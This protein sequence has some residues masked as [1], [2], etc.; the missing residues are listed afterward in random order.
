L[1]SAASSL[2]ILGSFPGVQS[3]EQR[4]YYAHPRNGFWPIMAQLLC[5]DP[6]AAYDDR[7]EALVGQGVALW[8]VLC[9]C[10]RKGSLDSAIDA[11]SVVIND[12]NA[13]F[14]AHRNIQALIFNG[15]RAEET[16]IKSV[17]PQLDSPNRPK[18]MHRLPST[19]PAMAMLS[20]EEKAKQWQ[21]IMK[22]IKRA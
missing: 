1:S 9:R 7:V 20:L 5:F 4:Q 11:D 21:L 14:D 12:F 3:L 2:L 22:Y 10:R 18:K 13:F 16:F 6:G 19:S 8:D 15:L 17:L